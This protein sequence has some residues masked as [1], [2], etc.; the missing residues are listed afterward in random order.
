MR[1]IKGGAKGLHIYV[2]TKMERI[3]S[4]TLHFLFSAPHQ[5]RGR[6]ACRAMPPISAFPN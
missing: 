6:R 5:K 1:R 4:D 3:C 2:D